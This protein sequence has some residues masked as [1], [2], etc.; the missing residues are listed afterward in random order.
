MQRGITKEQAAALKR[1]FQ[2]ADRDGSGA[3][4]ANEFAQVMRSCGMAA[5]A[6]ELAQKF[7]DYD[8]DGN[9]RVSFTEFMATFHTPPPQVPDA[10]KMRDM[11]RGADGKW[12]DTRFPPNNNSIFA[13]PNPAADHVGDVEGHAG[14]T[15]NGAPVQWVRAYELCGG[16]GQAKLFNGVHPNDIAQGVLGDCWFLAALAGLAEFEGAILNLFQEKKVNPDGMYTVN[17][18]NPQTNLWDAV[19]IDDWI[20]LRNGEPLFAKPQGNEMWVLLL[21]KAFAKWFGSY[22]Q[23]QGAYCMV[24]YLLLVNCGAPC[25]VFTQSM[26]GRAPFNEQVYDSVNCVLNDPK[27]RNSV[28]LA[29][30]GQVPVDQ[31]WNELVAADA[32]NHVMAA[33]TGK[34]AAQSAGRGASG[35]EIA[36]DGIVKGHA[37]SLI[38]AKQVTADGKVFRCVQLRNPW[39]A[40]PAAEYKGELSDDWPLW[41]NYPELKRTLLG[42]GG[43]LDGMFWMTFEKFVERYSDCGIVPKTMETPRMGQLEHEHKTP[44]PVAGKHGRRQNFF[45]SVM[46]SVQSAV[47]ASKPPPK[48][49]KPKKGGCC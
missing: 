27:N 43:K 44:H 33:W 29:R 7:K 3:L 5:S 4:D 11:R 1:A 21:E 9:G 30:A 37:Y 14:T 28:G 24:A 10:I 45:Q 12:E 34:D 31:V 16:A 32:S 6:P 20:P 38:S 40:N 13:S 17:I 19:T 46:N 25:K 47:P 8:T 41:N 39:G 22:C 26:S 2:A 36:S 18:F 48:Q 49:K 42:D 23:I 35:E 15:L